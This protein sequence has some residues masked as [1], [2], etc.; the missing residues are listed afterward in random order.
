MTSSITIS[1]F[2]VLHDLNRWVSPITQPSKRYSHIINHILS[3]PSN[4]Y[5]LNEITA[6]FW[7]KL[8]SKL[9]NKYPYFS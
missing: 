6:S 8:L 7:P 9:S 2:N 1:T 3:S 4:I 5:C